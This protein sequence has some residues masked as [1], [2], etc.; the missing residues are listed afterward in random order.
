MALCVKSR[1][2]ETS[3]DAYGS[4]PRVV[5]AAC[6]YATYHIAAVNHDFPP[7]S[8]R[9]IVIFVNVFVHQAL[10]APKGRQITKYR[11]ESRT[12]DAH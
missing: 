3:K 12:N 2:K 8:G 11:V 7:P 6:D 4:V 5:T 1:Q 10:S 9:V